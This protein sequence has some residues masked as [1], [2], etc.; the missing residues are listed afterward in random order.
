MKKVEKCNEK[1]GNN[2]EKVERRNERKGVMWEREKN[3]MKE[4]KV[5]KKEKCDEI[6]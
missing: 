4:S 1:K 3:V 5:K 6:K 2:V